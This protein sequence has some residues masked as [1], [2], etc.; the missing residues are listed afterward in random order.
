MACGRAWPSDLH[1]LLG[2]WH[3]DHTVGPE[4]GQN[5]S[6]TGWALARG[7]TFSSHHDAPVAFP[8]S[9]RVRDATVTRRA[10]GS[11]RIVG[12][13]L[14]VDVITA[15]KEGP[16]APSATF[17]AGRRSTTG[18]GCGTLSR[19]EVDRSPPARNIAGKT[20]SPAH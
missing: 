1:L 4:A 8:D 9:M 15:L 2:D 13:D 7:M 5:I 14:R 19:G 17:D 10:R 12:A 20:E 11:G 16:S 6:P 3:R 18:L